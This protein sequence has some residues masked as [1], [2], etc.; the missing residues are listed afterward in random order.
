MTFVRNSKMNGHEC[1]NSEHQIARC[2]TIAA[3]T[4]AMSVLLG[5][6]SK[7]PSTMQDANRESQ[8][9]QF[10]SP[11]TLLSELRASVLAKDEALFLK[12]FVESDSFRQ[13]LKATF[14]RIQA[15]LHFRDVV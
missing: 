15:T 10:D 14:Q 11:S 2:A 3:T 7:P 5:G 6:C 9:M 12:C 1:R 4:L 8:T 13:C